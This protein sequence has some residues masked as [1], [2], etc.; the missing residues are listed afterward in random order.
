MP[1]ATNTNAPARS[2]ARGRFRE[3]HV[4]TVPDAMALREP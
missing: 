3:Y 2:T 4:T 1:D